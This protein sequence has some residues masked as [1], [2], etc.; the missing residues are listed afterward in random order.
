LDRQEV[1]KL[2]IE[3][4]PFALKVFALVVLYSY[5]ARLIL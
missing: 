4:A 2:I 1:K 5:L 3:I